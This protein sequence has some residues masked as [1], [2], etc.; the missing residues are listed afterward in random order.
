[1]SK[2]TWQFTVVKNRKD[3]L[4]AGCGKSAGPRTL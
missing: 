1:M 2:Q 4:L 3:Q